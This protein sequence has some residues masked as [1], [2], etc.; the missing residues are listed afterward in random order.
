[1]AVSSWCNIVDSQ[2]G[3]KAS[4]IQPEEGR[5]DSSGQ[6]PKSTIEHHSPYFSSSPHWHV[7]SEELQSLLAT[8]VRE[9]FVQ[10]SQLL[11]CQEKMKDDDIGVSLSLES[12]LDLQTVA[13]TAGHCHANT[14]ISTPSHSRCHPQVCRIPLALIFLLHQ[15]HQQHFESLGFST[16]F[17][18]TNR[19]NVIASGMAPN[20]RSIVMSQSKQ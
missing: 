7:L 3:S 15:A 17:S 5:E 20:Y 4:G 2:Q 19:K 16:A 10:S 13:T 18:T 11:Q 8:D 1:L 6:K 12:A 14:S 9:S